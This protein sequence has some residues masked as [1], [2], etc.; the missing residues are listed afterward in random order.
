MAKIIKFPT[1]QMGL[2]VAV[3][4]IVAVAL[5]MGL[6]LFNPV[7]GVAARAGTWVRRLFGGMTGTKA[8]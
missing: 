7:M 4:A 3:I 2:G 8:A 1:R 6:G 5:A